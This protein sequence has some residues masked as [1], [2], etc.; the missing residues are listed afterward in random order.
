M[1]GTHSVRTEQ[2]STYETRAPRAVRS[3]SQM[4]PVK[5]QAGF[6]KSCPPLYFVKDGYAAASVEYRFASK[7]KFPAQ[8]QDCQAAVRWLRGNAKKCNLD[9]ER[10]AV[11]G[12]SAGGHLAA[13][14][15]TAGGSGAFEPVGGYR[16]QSDRVQAVCDFFGPANFMTVIRQGN[17]S[18]RLQL[19]VEHHEGVGAPIAQPHEIVLIDEH[20]VGLRAVAG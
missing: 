10:F 20:R 15:G 9:P 12:E 11:W 13:L 5:S 2:P 14:L 1:P 7:A 18:E 19:R 6:K 3:T 17:R 4:R 16:D 8:I